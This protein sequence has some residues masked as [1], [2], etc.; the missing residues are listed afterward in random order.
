MKLLRIGQSVETPV[1]KATIFD[2]DDYYGIVF[3]RTSNADLH[4]ELSD[5]LFLNQLREEDDRDC[6]DA[7][8]SDNLSGHSY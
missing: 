1:G 8:G 4:F 7:Y 5:I 3:V 2:I 6:P